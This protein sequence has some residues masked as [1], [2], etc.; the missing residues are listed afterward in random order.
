ML[1]GRG[2]RAWP[3]LGANRV[4]RQIGA[5]RATRPSHMTE[6]QRDRELDYPTGAQA[7]GPT[8]EFSFGARVKID[9]L[10]VIGP[11]KHGARQLFPIAGGTVGG[12]LSGQVLP[13][14][15]DWQI[16]RADGVLELDARYTIQADDD[17]L[18]HVRNRGIMHRDNGA[19]YARTAADFEAPLDG[20]HAWLN[21][22]IFVGDVALRDSSTV[23]VRFFRVG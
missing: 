8:C 23:D 9:P 2:E 15:A 3:R 4:T 1:R 6:Q 20:P 19:P 16:V 14:G 13:G 10:V 5:R 7:P 22:A 18:V 12:Q 11:S 17:S 21:R